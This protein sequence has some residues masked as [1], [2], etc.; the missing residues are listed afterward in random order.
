MNAVTAYKKATYDHTT[1]TPAGT[2]INVASAQTAAATPTWTLLT[3]S[4]MN[5]TT[6][7]ARLCSC[8][9][10]VTFNGT[11]AENKAAFT[12]VATAINSVTSAA[13]LIFISE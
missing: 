9:P 3:T 2:K 4:E 7:T 11:L 12:L 8:K 1:S 13:K 5:F 10:K 6:G